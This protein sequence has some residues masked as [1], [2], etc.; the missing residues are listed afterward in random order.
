MAKKQQEERD[1]SRD[2]AEDIPIPNDIRHKY[3]HL[4]YDKALKIVLYGTPFTDSRPRF[5][6]EKIM[7]N[8]G[9]TGK[10]FNPIPKNIGIIRKVFKDLYV[11]SELLQNTCIVSPYHIQCKAFVKVSGTDLKWI[12]KSASKRTQK[13]LRDEKLGHVI[14]KDIDNIVKIHNDLLLSK[15]YLISVNDG[16][17]VGLIDTEKYLTLDNPRVEMYVYYASKPFDYHRYKIE[18]TKEYKYFVYSYKNMLMNK[19]DLKSQ[20]KYLVKLTREYI[21]ENAKEKVIIKEIKFLSKLFLDNR[22]YPAKLIKEL[23]GLEVSNKFNRKDAV[24]KLILYLI[25]DNKSASDY[26]NKQIGGIIDYANIDE[27]GEDIS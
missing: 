15:E 17:N 19:R 6:P 10:I 26:I 16:P 20:L 9:N 22:Q 3:A 8:F 23:A 18:A 4:G 27:S 25:K 11:N 5:D 13:L 14:D 7:A 1:T 2:Y 12:E 21:P 24:V